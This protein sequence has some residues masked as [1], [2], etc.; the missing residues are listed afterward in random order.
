MSYSILRISIRGFWIPE[1]TEPLVRR[2]AAGNTMQY[3]VIF[4]LCLLLVVLKTTII[5]GMLGG[6]WLYDLLIP[7]VI[8]FSLYRSLTEGL[9]V[10]LISAIM[11]DMISGA[12]AGI[13]L[14]TYIWLFLAFR[15]TWRFLDLRHTYLF[16][17]IVV[18]GVVFQQLIFWV[19]A[20]VSAGQLVFSYE[21]IR[22]VFFQILWAVVSAPL[23]YLFFYKFFAAAD[24][25][26][27]GNISENGQSG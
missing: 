19:A 25:L 10:V 27:S 24:R 23:L 2:D 6:L 22:I 3:I 8:Y 9:P 14:T 17:A 21:S 7:L 13:Y 18:A 1:K 5:P 4:I 20:S 15:Q 26:F 11:M 12:P 16:P